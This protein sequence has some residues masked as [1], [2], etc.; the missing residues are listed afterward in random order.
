MVK[1][2]ASAMAL[3]AAAVETLALVAAAATAEGNSDGG[4]NRV[5]NGSSG[6]CGY[7]GG[8]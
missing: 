1:T 3:T 8:K 6:D 7:G 4:Q 2:E 5:S